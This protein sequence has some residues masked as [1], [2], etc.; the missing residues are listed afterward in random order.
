MNMKILYDALDKTNAIALATSADNIPNVRVVNFCYDKNRSGI[1]Y[2]ASDRENQKVKELGDNPHI[3]FTTIPVGGASVPH[4]RSNRAIAR[5][6]HKTLSEVQ[7]L[8]I[9]KIPGYDETITAIGECLDVF[10][11]QIN[12]ATVIVDFDT[13]HTIRFK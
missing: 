6:S 13:V 4:V 5:K 2:F 3:A 9:S 8:F 11:I 12:E 1:L 7:D 10:E